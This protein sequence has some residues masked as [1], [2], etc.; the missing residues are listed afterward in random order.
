MFR[1]RPLKILRVWGVFTLIAIVISVIHLLISS[2]IYFMIPAT[3]GLMLIVLMYEYLSYRVDGPGY[4]RSFKDERMWEISNEAV[5]ISCYYFFVTIWGLALI[6]NFPHFS[7]IKEHIS[8]VLGL[9][10]F[11]G[12]IIHVGSFA[13]KKYRI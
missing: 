10:V 11:V 1:L 12:L 3:A 5:R 9:I 13:W 4:D 8:A 6:L 7:F 2:H